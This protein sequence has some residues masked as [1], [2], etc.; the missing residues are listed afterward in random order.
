[1]NLTPLIL[2]LLSVSL[3]HVQSQGT[4][5]DDEG[6]CVHPE[7][8]TECARKSGRSGGAWVV[9][10]DI[11]ACVWQC[12]EEGKNL[13]LDGFFETPQCEYSRNEN[14]C[15]YSYSTNWMGVGFVILFGCCCMT[16]CVGVVFRGAL[17]CNGRSTATPP[18]A[19]V[20]PPGHESP[21]YKPGEAAQ[22]GGGYSYTQTPQHSLFSPPASAPAQY[23]DAS[24]T[25]ATPPISN[26][27]TGYYEQQQQ[28][29]KEQAQ[30]VLAMYSYP[31]G[32]LNQN[33]QL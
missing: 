2:L 29:Q 23:Y 26:M 4:T 17:L 31:T 33:K 20:P 6:A 16:G 19:T 32:D 27:P 10:E 9:C 25:H 3:I 13:F 7:V 11:C 30:Q 14:D 12:D 1:M 8:G 21:G 18:A 28:P 5:D 24:T 22:G 15:R